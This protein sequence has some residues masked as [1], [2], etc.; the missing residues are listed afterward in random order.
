MAEAQGCPPRGNLLSP[1]IV[2]RFLCA[3]LGGGL[4][5]QRVQQK[6][7]IGHIVVKILFGKAL[8]ALI[9]PGGHAAP[10]L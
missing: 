3:E 7:H 1:K 9:F 8:E 6:F 5:G 4:F 10:S 2:N